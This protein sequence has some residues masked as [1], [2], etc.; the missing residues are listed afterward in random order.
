MLLQ[1]HSGEIHLLP[2]LPKAWPN[3]SVKGLRAR[4]GFEV[5]IV[6][7]DSQL[8]TGTIKSVWGTDFKLRY[9]SRVISLRMRSGRSL[10]FDENLKST[11]QVS[12]PL[13]TKPNHSTPVISHVRNVDPVPSS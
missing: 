3:G 7:E 9:G 12:M 13:P 8:K 5:D 1:S 11:S 10:R 2:A 4:G 6:W